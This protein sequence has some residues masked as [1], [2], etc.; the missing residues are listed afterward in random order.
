MPDVYILPDPLQ[1]VLQLIATLIMFL[2]VRYFLWGS[3]TK[4]IEEKRALSVAEINEAQAKNEEA[5]KLLA[6]AEMTVKEAREKATEI[7]GESKK[8]ANAVHERIILDAKKEADYL[9][10]NAKENIEQEKL[11][12]YDKLKTEVV[13]LTIVAT[14]K[15]IE[16]EI[17]EK[18]QSDIVN[19][20]IEGVS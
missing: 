10:A 16:G 5:D 20:L 6:E 11:H 1:M 2:A 13:D 19:N 14:S 9:K 15:I 3:V 8:S 12:F 18:K 17:D 4:F 7:V